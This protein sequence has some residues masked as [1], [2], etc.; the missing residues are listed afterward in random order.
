MPLVLEDQPDRVLEKG[1][2]TRNS[3]NFGTILFTLLKCKNHHY[4]CAT[5]LGYSLYVDTKDTYI[6]LRVCVSVSVCVPV[7]VCVCVCVYV[8]G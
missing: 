3:G 7:Y 6:D 1:N 2:V 4:I 8:C 5:T